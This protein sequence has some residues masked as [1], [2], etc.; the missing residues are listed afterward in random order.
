MCVS[1]SDRN[2]FRCASYFLSYAGVLYAKCSLGL[3]EIKEP[4]NGSK[5]LNAFYIKFHDNPLSPAR[6]VVS[7]QTY[8]WTDRA[9]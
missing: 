8:M 1:T 4:R 9:F 6:I 3:L 7:V 2:I 5:I